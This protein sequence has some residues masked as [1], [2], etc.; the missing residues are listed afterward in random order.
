[1]ERHEVLRTVF[2]APGGEPRLSVSAAADVP[3]V[4]RDVGGLPA[5]EREGEALR[6]LRAWAEEP[7]DLA[8]GPLFRAGLVRLADD[9]H[10]LG[11]FLHHIVCDGPS[12]HLLFDELAIL[13]AGG[14]P[15]ALPA[16]FTDFAA[17]QAAAEPGQGLAW[18]RDHLE[19]VPAVLALPTDRPRPARRSWTG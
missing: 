15:P 11:I 6:V 5:G 3:L 19:G 10:L 16:Q 2:P 17:E 8:S 9:E 12:M 4:L 7:F 14:E 13:Y 18:W 1:A